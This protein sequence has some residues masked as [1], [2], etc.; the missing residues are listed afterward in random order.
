MGISRER[1]AIATILP[2]L[3]LF[4]GNLSPSVPAALAGEVERGTGNRLAVPKVVGDPENATEEAG[5]FILHRVILKNSTVIDAKRLEGIAAPYLGKTVTYSEL[6]EIL[7][8]LIRIYSDNG[9]ITSTVLL[10]AREIVGGVVVY[11]AIERGAGLEITGTRR[12]NEGYLRSRLEGAL[13][14]PLKLGNV[15]AA[16]TLLRRNPLFTDLQAD[17]GGTDSENAVLAVKVTEAPLYSVGVEASNDENPSVGETGVRFFAEDRSLSGNGDHLYLEYKIT[18]GLN[19][20]LASYNYP[21]PG[22]RGRFEIS[23]QNSDSRIVSGFFEPFDVRSDGYILGAGLTGTIVNTPTDNLEVG[24][25]VDRRENRSYVLG[26][27]LYADTRLTLL[28]LDTSYLN[29]GPGVFTIGISRLSYGWDDLGGEEIFSWQGQTQT[30]VSLTPDLD[31]YGRLALQLSPSNLPPVERCAIGG[32]NGNQLIFGNTVRGYFTNTSLG[33]NCVALSTEL[34]YTVYRDGNSDLQVF[35]FL[36][37]GTV[38][39]N[40]EAVLSPGTLIGTG[41]GLRYS[42]GGFLQAQL[43]Y[44]FPLTANRDL[45]QGFSFSVL[46]QW[47]F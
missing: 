26:D 16:L 42:L 2:S 38:W 20:F 4:F 1:K 36:D 40:E 33:D 17:L 10:P 3:F 31:W 32:R 41:V 5:E 43:N 28:R 7:E 18:E 6:Q 24:L 13:K 11:E 39:N 25:R 45:Q 12:V 34:R 30:L 19:R 27:R 15:E 8:N 14:A 9:Y 23:Y 46:G 35:P 21:L 22:D 37:L 29:R 47:R 44:G